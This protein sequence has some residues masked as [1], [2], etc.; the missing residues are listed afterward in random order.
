MSA[1]TILKR[2]GKSTT[3][4]IVPCLAAINLAS[5]YAVENTDLRIDI[6]GPSERL[7]VL[8]KLD[9]WA[10]AARIAERKASNT[11][12]VVFISSSLGISAANL[13]DHKKYG[14]PDLKIETYLAY[15]KYRC[16][17]D[18]LEKN[19]GKTTSTVNFSNAASLISEDLL[20]AREAVR[21][22]GKPALIVLGIAPRDFLDHYTNAYHRSRLAQILMTRQIESLWRFNKSAQ[23]NLDALLARIWP[24]YSQRVEHKDLAIKLAC[25]RF[26][27]S[28]DL[29]SAVTRAPA[30]LSPVTS[31]DT[32]AGDSNF[33]S[34][35][36]FGKKQAPAENEAAATARDTPPTE[37]VLKKFDSDYR[38]RYLPLDMDRWELEM[39]SLRE[40]VTFCN[41]EQ[42]PLMIVGMPLSERNR[43]LIPAQFLSKHLAL[44]NEATTG[45]PYVRF[46]N[47]IDDP[48]FLPE[49]YSD[50]VHLRSPGSFK[51]VQKVGEAVKKTGWLQ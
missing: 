44:V 29:F 4:W 11:L 34:D 50:T 38:G 26:N 18:A 41:S 1:L 43:A 10:S 48:D 35:L 45:Q 25:Q 17:D 39:K 9:E 8:R 36:L 37:A 46:L 30:P 49:D 27:R 7:I 40:F 6:L 14:K 13:G 2:I 5:W 31:D 23:E 22:Q 19:T 15:D 3:I 12:P 16:L 21:K 24:Y 51:L 20:I 42:I 47:L 33:F 28:A 32:T